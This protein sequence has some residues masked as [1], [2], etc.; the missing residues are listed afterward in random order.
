MDSQK[1]LQPISTTSLNNSVYKMLR[2]WILDQELSPGQRL[3]LNELEDQLHVS[4]TPIKMAFKQLELEGLVEIVPRRGT[5]IASIDIEKLDENYKICSSFELYVA[6]CLH[7]YLNDDDYLFFE[8]LRLEMNQLV[9]ASGADFQTL[10]LDYLEFDKQ[11]HERLIL[12][13]GSQRMLDIYR[14]M[15]IHTLMTR[16]VP[17]FSLSHFKAMHLE[18]V[19]L[20]KAIFEQNPDKL[21]HSLYNHLEAERQ[22]LGTYFTSQK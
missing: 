18:H 19:E 16:I 11:L 1:I 6:L 9:S 7:K 21:S 14:Q 12:R 8:A 13:G 17:H 20:F 22:R 4:R 3:N 10:I 15:N 5:F 2:K